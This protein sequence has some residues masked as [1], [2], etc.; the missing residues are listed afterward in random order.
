MRYI[1]ITTQTEFK[2][3]IIIRFEEDK[4]SCTSNDKPVYNE[5]GVFEK[6]KLVFTSKLP[7]G[8][9]V[10]KWYVNG[11][12]KTIGT[13]PKQFEY[14]VYAD[15]AETEGNKKVM[16]ITIDEK[17]LQKVKINYNTELV[18]CKG[19]DENVI[20]TGDAIYEVTQV[21]LTAKIKDSESISYWQ[22]GKKK[23]NKSDKSIHYTVS[24]LDANNESGTPVIDISY[25][26]KQKIA[27]KFDPSKITCE[28]SDGSWF[29]PKYTSVQNGQL[30]DVGSF[31]RFY[32]VKPNKE[33]FVCWLVNGA[34]KSE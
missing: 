30:I 1:E 23:I 13:S 32:T 24:V 10:A 33:T 14:V 19:E 2:P 3:R 25:V 29:L 12:E 9:A 34:E 27:I 20:N 28:V 15:Q 8:K 6:E 4:L 26:V 16:R 31:L 18:E 5:Q 21:I 17:V 7:E 22:V 11:K